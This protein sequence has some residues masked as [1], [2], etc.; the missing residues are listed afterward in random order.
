MMC[1]EMGVH[2]QASN[3]LGTRSSRITF[4]FLYN[5]VTQLISQVFVRCAP[6]RNNPISK[7]NTLFCAPWKSSSIGIQKTHLMYGVL[8]HICLLYGPISFC[9]NE[10]LHE[11]VQIGPPHT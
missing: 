3:A 2:S 6:L 11:V 7:A 4:G 10:R 5:N 8:D 1:T 9:S